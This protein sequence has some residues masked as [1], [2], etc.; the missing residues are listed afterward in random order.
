MATKAELLE[1]AEGLGLSGFSEESS[2]SEIKDAINKIVSGKSL[3]VA[4]L[5]ERSRR[6]FGQPRSVVR[7]AVSAGFLKDPSTIGAAETAI[8]K[9]LEYVPDA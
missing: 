9:F 3:S 1:Q 7:G 4:Q 5:E 8:Q 6:L 2:V